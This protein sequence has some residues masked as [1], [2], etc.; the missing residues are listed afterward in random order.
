MSP[1]HARR[2]RQ[3]PSDTSIIGLREA[4]D[5]DI[6]AMAQLYEGYMKRFDMAFLMT[7]ED[8]A[9]H[10][11]GAKGTGDIKDGKRN[12]QTVWAY[13]VEVYILTQCFESADTTP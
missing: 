7:R 12:G 5:R 4:E 6:D 9:H 3:I 13:V 11:F 2:F 10:F 8:C 1:W